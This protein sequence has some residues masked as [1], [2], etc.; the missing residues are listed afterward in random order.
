MKLRTIAFVLV[1]AMLTGCLVGC[2]KE[3]PPADQESVKESEIEGSVPAESTY[4]KEG[5][6]SD[7]DVPFES[8]TSFESANGTESD[9][10]RQESA[11]TEGETKAETETENGV[12]HLPMDW[13]S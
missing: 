5:A 9:S 8:D 10:Q 7:E 6:S 13:F 1:C 2:A 3:L 4:E 12:I 11:E